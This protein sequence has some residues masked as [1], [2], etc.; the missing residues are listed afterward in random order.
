MKE[1]DTHETEV[2]Q[3][4]ISNY[5]VRQNSKTSDLNTFSGFSTGLCAVEDAGQRW[6]WQ[7]DPCQ[8]AKRSGQGKTVCHEIAQKSDDCYESEGYCTYQGRE[9]YSGYK[10]KCL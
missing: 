6:I 7:G 5:K 10:T 1:E 9:K 2:N 8:K 3:K 4:L